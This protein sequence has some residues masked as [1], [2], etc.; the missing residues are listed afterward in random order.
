MENINPFELFKEELDTDDLAARVN[1]IHK[2]SIVATLMPIEAVRNT[3]IPFLDSLT[4][5]EDDEVV[6]AITEEYA[7]LA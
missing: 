7:T 4:K 2:V 3:L 1:T 6:Y 5:K